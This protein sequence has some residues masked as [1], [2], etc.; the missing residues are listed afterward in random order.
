MD[1]RKF[2]R[3]EPGRGLD[4]LVEKEYLNGEIAG[5]QLF[6]RMPELIIEDFEQTL[7]ELKEDLNDGR[8]D[9]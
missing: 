3:D 2:R 6:T 1:T 9:S 4:H 7:D 8:E 5:I